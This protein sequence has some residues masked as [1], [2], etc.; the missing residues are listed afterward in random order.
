MAVT[1]VPTERDNKKREKVMYPRPL[2]ARPPGLPPPPRFNGKAP[3]K[4]PATI[5]VKMAFNGEALATFNLTLG[6]RIV[7]LKRALEKLCGVPTKDQQLIHCT[8]A[9]EL[10]DCEMLECAFVSSV[11]EGE[12]L[13]VFRQI[14]D[15][16][17]V[18]QACHSGN[19]L[20]VDSLVKSNATVNSACERFGTSPLHIAA[21]MARKD[22]VD[23]LLRAV[24]DLNIQDGNGRTALHVAVSDDVA[25]SLL[26]AEADCLCMDNSGKT[27][28]TCIMPLFAWSGNEMMVEHLLRNRAL[29]NTPY[30]SH[31]VST[32]HFC[33]DGL[34]SG[35]L[36]HVDGNPAL[37]CA[38]K[39]GHEH[40]V[41]LLAGVTSLAT[42]G[43]HGKTALHLAC[44]AGSLAVCMAILNEIEH[45]MLGQTFQLESP[46]AGMWSALMKEV[47]FARKVFFHERAITQRH[48]QHFHMAL[49]LY[50]DLRNEDQDGNTPLH[51]ACW[52]GNDDIVWLLLSK[53]ADL[54]AESHRNESPLW[55]ATVNGRLNICK[56][57]LESRANVCERSLS[58][59]TLLHRTAWA[60]ELKL[61]DLL[62][63][64]KAD[65]NVTN[66]DGL[67]PFQLAQSY[68]QLIP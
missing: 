46:V 54:Y 19:R 41:A 16:Q 31:K 45:P 63:Q 35:V 66:N 18:Q 58:G 26:D 65:T 29:A 57:L 56:L 33:I 20:L 37:H 55:V 62:I 1:I 5:T 23:I 34:H 13:L 28:G 67:T 50:A 17:T 22:I 43:K 44:K 10:L 53:R 59:D 47:R 42:P 27:A 48:L 7:E 64:A 12:V 25:G 60:G 52:A 3:A 4:G 51:E 8:S 39:G 40:I 32:N 15:K 14:E 36:V 24:A 21:R 61:G 2:R 49:G 30:Q 11:H 68:G 6:T 9:R 38:V